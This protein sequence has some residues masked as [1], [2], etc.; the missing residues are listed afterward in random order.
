MLDKTLS[1]LE[2][3]VQSFEGLESVIMPR[4]EM[5][6]IICQVPEL[7]IFHIVY[8]GEQK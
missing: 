8:A 3:M 1:Y 2:A 7:R 6:G 5:A 4:S